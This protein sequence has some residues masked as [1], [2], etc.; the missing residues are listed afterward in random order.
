[1]HCEDAEQLYENN[2]ELYKDSLGNPIWYEAPKNRTNL[3]FRNKNTIS[4]NRKNN[5]KNINVYKQI[6]KNSY[7]GS[8][9]Y[10]DKN[11]RNFVKNKFNIDYDNRFDS[12]YE[13]IEAID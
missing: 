3:Y 2:N 4:S 1:M 10:K 12:E 8:L 5:R 9:K 11:T 7:R 6:S 13:I